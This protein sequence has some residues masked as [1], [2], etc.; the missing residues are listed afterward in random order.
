[1]DRTQ[2]RLDAAV[3]AYRENPT[4]ENRVALMVIMK[5]HNDKFL[6]EQAQEFIQRTTEEEA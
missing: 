4:E 6:A 5:E 2:G 1:M 3:I